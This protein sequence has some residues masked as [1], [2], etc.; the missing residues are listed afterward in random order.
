MLYTT[1]YD[2]REDICYLPAGRSYSGNAQANNR[3]IIFPV[4]NRLTSRFVYVTL[5]LNWLTCR[6]QTIAKNLTREQTSI[7]QILNKDIEQRK[8][9]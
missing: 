4:A 2:A 3:F 8:M 5:S 1:F 7:T 6:V 9:C